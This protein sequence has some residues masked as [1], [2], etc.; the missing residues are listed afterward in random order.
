MLYIY[1]VKYNY[2]RFSQAGLYFDF[3]LKKISEL[4]VRNVFLYT[5]QYFGEKYFIEVF[6][7]KF[8][9]KSIFFLNNFFS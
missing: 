6:T 5:S 2:F 7:K 1:V 9:S 8:I 3:F 4:F